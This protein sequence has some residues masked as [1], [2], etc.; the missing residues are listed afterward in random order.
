MMER[1]EQD[2]HLKNQKLNK[3]Y[4]LD[5]FHVEVFMKENINYKI[6]KYLSNH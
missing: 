3:E 2:L 5:D 1:K 4:F 6:L